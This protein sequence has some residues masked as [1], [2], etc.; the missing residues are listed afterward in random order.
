MAL[1]LES[2]DANR[3]ELRLPKLDRVGDY[4]YSTLFV[5]LEASLTFLAT[6]D[7]AA[8]RCFEMLA[9]FP[10][11]TDVPMAILQDLWMISPAA[12]QACCLT[13]ADWNLVE[14]QE[15]EQ[16]LYVLDLHRDY[17][18]ARGKNTLREWNAMLLDRVA[19]DGVIECVREDDDSRTTY[20]SHP[21]S[22]ERFEHHWYE[23]QGCCRL[24]ALTLLYLG[25][26]LPRI[27]T[28]NSTL[29]TLTLK[30]GSSGSLDLDKAEFRIALFEALRTT[31]ITT[32]QLKGHTRSAMNLRA[33]GAR[34]LAVV[35][36]FW[37]SITALSL[38]QNYIGPDGL[39]ALAEVLSR[40]SI[41]DLDLSWNAICD[42]RVV[43]GFRGH[44]PI[45]FT[46][47]AVEALVVALRN[48]PSPLIALDLSE[49]DIAK[50]PNALEALMEF[51][52][53]SYLTRL[54]LVGNGFSHDDRA[55]LLQVGN[56]ISELTLWDEEEEDGE[57]EAEEEAEEGEEEGEEESEQEPPDES[58]LE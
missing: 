3:G 32:L 12:T 5:A 31:S 56:A 54:N 39:T 52:P 2:L 44:L 49:N 21:Q 17:L 15:A 19:V 38:R 8:V 7:E 55:R 29:R 26:E 40:T 14:Y 25:Q 41:T 11:D 27:L 53:S 35:L 6:E 37:P 18:R 28:G 51:L 43:C 48:M 16:T 30:T 24:R 45:S 20:F 46:A 4:Y 34:H 13:L 36:P 23:A 9:I 1:V 42:D 10:E 33:E 57:G 50:D 58:E 47:V 22:W